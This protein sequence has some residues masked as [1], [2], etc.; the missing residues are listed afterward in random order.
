MGGRIAQLTISEKSLPFKVPK[1]LGFSENPI[2]KF[3][4]TINGEM[5]INRFLQ[6]TVL[7]V[8]L[9]FQNQIQAQEFG[10]YVTT[11]Q[12]TETASTEYNSDEKS[13]LY[14]PKNG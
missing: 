8:I 12:A 6:I 13:S 2:H 3:K 1:S 9:L 4:M 7:L 11:E 10:G 5:M 14:I